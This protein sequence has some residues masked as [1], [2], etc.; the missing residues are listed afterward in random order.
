MLGAPKKLECKL[1]LI[2]GTHEGDMYR[3]AG[4]PSILDR[5]RKY[6]DELATT[7][8]QETP[9]ATEPQPKKAKKER[10]AGNEAHDAECWSCCECP[11]FWMDPSDPDAS[12]RDWI[13]CIGCMRNLHF[14]CSD[15][16]M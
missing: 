6:D 2:S 16:E 9:A 4:L 11:L 3:E 10:T 8:P 15:L 1:E 13:T 14:D 12:T 5:Y 7:N